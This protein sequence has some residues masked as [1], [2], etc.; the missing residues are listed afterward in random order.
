MLTA[1]W[2]HLAEQDRAVAMPV[3]A[4]LLSPPGVMVMALRHGPA[5]EGRMMFA[6]SPQETIGL[7]PGGRAFGAFSMCRSNRARKKIGAPVSL[8]HVLAFG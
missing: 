8:G 6:V 1:A 7:S 3:L 4:R 2:M 5:P